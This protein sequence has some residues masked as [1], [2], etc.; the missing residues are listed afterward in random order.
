MA[1][2]SSELLHGTL[3]TLILKTLAGGRRHGYGIARAIEDATDGVV[4]VEDGSLYPALYRMERRG[5]IEA[6]WG[7]SELGRRAKFY[8]ITARGRRQLASQ[9]AEWARFAGAISKVLL[10]NT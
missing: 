3:E 10:A 5:L 4:D 9:T 1:D 6:E 2:T 8:R 7:V